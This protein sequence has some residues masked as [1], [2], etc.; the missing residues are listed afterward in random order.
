MGAKNNATRCNNEQ[1]YTG[2]AYRD[3]R[4]TDTGLRQA[5]GLCAK[6]SRYRLVGYSLGFRDSVLETPSLTLFG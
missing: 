6:V 3:R 1:R 2:A 5:A 4:G